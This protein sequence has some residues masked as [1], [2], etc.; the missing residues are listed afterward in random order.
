MA[1]PN[2]WSLGVHLSVKVTR[3]PPHAPGTR[4]STGQPNRPAW[5]GSWTAQSY[6]VSRPRTLTSI[7]SCRPWHLETSSK[8]ERER[9][10]PSESCA[11]RQVTGWGRG[12]PPG[13]LRRERKGV[14]SWC[15]QSALGRAISQHPTTG[16]GLPHSSKIARQRRDRELCKH[17]HIAGS[18]AQFR[19][20]VLS[21]EYSGLLH[22]ARRNSDE[23]HTRGLNPQP[24]RR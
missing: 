1:T 2:S 14:L 16:I 6:L 3:H 10:G 15:A 5:S 11:E 24:P 20:P 22:Q 18:N 21:T 7:E 23:F 19:Y 13:K 12:A 4:E 9:G 17:G 8:R